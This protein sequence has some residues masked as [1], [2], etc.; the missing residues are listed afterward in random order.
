MLFYALH[1][2]LSFV[3]FH[4]VVP[5]IQLSISAFYLLRFLLAYG[6]V[7][8]STFVAILSIS[9][10]PSTHHVNVLETTVVQNRWLLHKLGVSYATN[11]SPPPVATNISSLTSFACVVSMLL[12][13]VSNLNH[14]EKESYG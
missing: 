9:W 2:S 12:Y 14:M 13:S 8:S 10:S 4:G 6:L 11:P 7:T 1:R 3:L 5:T